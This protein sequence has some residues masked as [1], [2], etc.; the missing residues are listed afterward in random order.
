MVGSRFTNASY[1]RKHLKCTVESH[2]CNQCDYASSGADSLRMHLKRHRED[3]S[4][5]CNQCY[6]ASS[7]VGNL[8]IHLKTQRGGNPNNCNRRDFTPIKS[9]NL[10][11]HLKIPQR[12]IA[13][14][15]LFITWFP[16]TFWENT[17][18]H[19]RD[20]PFQHILIVIGVVITWFL[21][22]CWEST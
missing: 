7:Q 11:S 16:T 2:K 19:F 4:N 5:T 15:S 14:R 3:K 18:T 22:A 17:A 9:G 8:M 12:H 6:F 20:K 13:A 21:P 1:L 10:R